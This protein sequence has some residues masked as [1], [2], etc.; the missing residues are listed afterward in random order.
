MLTITAQQADAL[1]KD[2]RRRFVDRMMAHVRQYFPRQFEK[3]GEPIVREWVEAGIKRSGEYGIVSERDVCK[4][5][6][7]MMVF[8]REFD[9]DPNCSWAPPI[10][11]AQP[12]DPALK[13]ER[14]FQTA[15]QQASAR[16]RNPNG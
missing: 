8:G 5:I 3:L 15:R 13:T 12:T 1:H 14:L 4:Y 9:K 11:T 6:D 10:L 16:N 7:V 2:L